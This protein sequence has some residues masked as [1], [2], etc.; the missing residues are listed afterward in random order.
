[1]IILEL[2]SWHGIKE[3]VLDLFLTNLS[4]YTLQVFMVS[5]LQEVVENLA[6][7]EVKTM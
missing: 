5:R 1:M 6:K 7:Q 2:F 4:I 3:A